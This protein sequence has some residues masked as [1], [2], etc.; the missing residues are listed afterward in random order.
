MIKSQTPKLVAW[1]WTPCLSPSVE[2]ASV[3]VTFCCRDENQDQS[4]LWKE[5]FVAAYGFTMAGMCG[6]KC[7]MV[8]PKQEAES[9]KQK[10]RECTGNTA[11]LRNP[12]PVL[13]RGTLP[14]AGPH[15]NGVTN[16]GPAIQMPKMMETMSFILGTVVMVEGS[17]SGN[18]SPQPMKEVS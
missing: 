8:W 16:W 11:R 7:Q 5:G 1:L 3:L 12:S 9:R 2:R 18:G 15:P 6:S 10:Q 4:T 17:P 14:L 13:F